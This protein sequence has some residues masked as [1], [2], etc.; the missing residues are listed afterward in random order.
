MAAVAQAQNTTDPAEAR[1]INAMFRQWG[2]SEN[3]VTQMGWNI[4]GELCTGAAVDS[5]DYDFEG[6]NPAIKCECNIPNSTT[7]HITR[8]KVFQMEAVGPIP[9]ELWTLSYL[10]NLNLARNYLTG[11]LSPSIG[12]LTRMQYLTFGTNALSGQVPPELGQLTELISLS[13]GWNNFNGSLPSELGNLK[14]LEQIYIDSCGIGGE[15]PPS[16]AN[17]QNLQIVWASDNNFT[18]RIPDFIGNWSQLVA[19]RFEGNS[20]EGSIPPSFSRLTGLQELRISGLSN[21]TLDFIRDLKSLGVLVLR[22]N[23]ISGSI[24]SDIGEYLN[25]T[26]LDLSFNNL[27]GPIPRELFNLRQI[28]FLFLG[29]NSFSGTLP[30]VKSTSLRNID[31]SYNELSGTL[32]S[33]AND[34]TLQLNIVVNNFTLN[35][36]GL[37]CLQRG[38]PCGRGSPRYSNFGINCGGPQITSSSQI[39]HEQD[40]EL[41]GPATYYVTPERRWAVS[42]VG[43]RDNPAYI[44]STSRLFT[45]TLDSELFQTARL[46]AGSLRYYGLGL[47]NGNYTL[48]LQ[49]AELVIPSDR[50][51]Q[52][53]GRRLFDIYIQGNRVFQDFDIKRE[54]GAASFSPVSREVTVRVSNNYLEIHLFWAGKGSCCVPELGTFGPLISAISATPNFIPTVSNKPPSTSKKNNTGLI[55]GIVVPIAVVS[56]LALLALYILRQRRK[57]KENDDNYDEEFLGIDTKPYT[58]G[59]GD[60]RDATN[61]FSPANKLGEGGFG[62]VYKGTLNDGRV[63]AVKQLSISS[64]QGKSQFVAEIATISA[65]QHRNLVKLYGCCIDGEKRLLVYEYLENKSL[66]QALFGSNKLLLTWPTRFEI[67]MGLARGLTYLHEESRIRVIHRDVKSSNVLL[68]SDLNPKISDFGLAKLYDDKKTHMNTRVAGTIGY[69]APEYAMRGHLTEKADV[70]GFGVVALEIISGRPNSDSTLEDEKVYLLEWAWNLHEANREIE[71]VDEEL[72]EFDENEVKRVMRVALLC[73]QTSPTQRPSMSRVVAMLLGDIEAIGHITRPQ[74]LTGISFDDATT[75]KSV[76]PTA[77]SD[78]VA[79]MSHSTVSSPSPLDISRPML[80]VL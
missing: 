35:N 27:S 47:E 9:E 38:F 40:N 63:I 58:F 39:V 52:S 15:I 25:L 71:V 77:V 24:P 14:R 32:P 19:L 80:Q 5:T 31:L 13:I 26:Q 2:I 64:R 57:R 69:L 59:Y 67:C 11:P 23:R 61:D 36:I 75:F 3:A 42:N 43:R 72:T 30:D 50:T 16:F 29:N 7:C 45:N 48:N 4:S 51:W 41:L 54:A 6:Y 65:V 37:N 78:D 46:S 55:V 18:G 68:D 12:N 34:P 74:Y 76:V 73:T 66:D 10:N 17:L 62:P 20:F 33:W 28:S 22:S 49:F 60:L 70:F 1:V 53:V 8:L 56:F 44:A 79:S 21:G